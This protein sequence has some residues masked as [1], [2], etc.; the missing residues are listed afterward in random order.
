[1]AVVLSII[2]RLLFALCRISDNKLLKGASAVYVDILRGTPLIVQ[3]LILYFGFPMFLQ[4]FGILFRWST[5][6]LASMLV[7]GINSSAYVGEIIRAGLQAVDKG[8]IEA[9]RSI[10]MTHGQTMRFVI[11]PQAFKII[12]P[13]LGNEFITLIKETAVLSVISVRDIT[14]ASM[15]WAS[16]SFLYWP[17]YLGTAACYLI[18]TIPL[19]KFMNWVERKLENDA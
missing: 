19:S 11:I 9:A 6:L 10:G 1:V 16:S 8:Q 4:S 17:A 18:L 3:A 14:R 15:L 12:I 2:L 13:A 5:P 7:C